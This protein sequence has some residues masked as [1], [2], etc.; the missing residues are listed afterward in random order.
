M[1]TFK[2]IIE[3]INATFGNIFFGM[4]ITELFLEK[5]YRTASYMIFIV[6]VLFVVGYYVEKIID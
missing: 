4:S 5:D 1:K 2:N 3:I 6:A